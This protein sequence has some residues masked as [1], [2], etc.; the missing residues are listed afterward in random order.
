MCWRCMLASSLP[1]SAVLPWPNP[2]STPPCPPRRWED[3]AEV[4]GEE[5]REEEGGLPPEEEPDIFELEGGWE[6]GV[7]PPCAG[8][9]ALPLS[10][11]GSR[12]SWPAATP[13]SARNKRPPLPRF[14]A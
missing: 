9:C 10:P 3:I 13:H 1:G 8:S 2:T 7:G 6:G 14:Q 11:D 12:G 5:A 4:R